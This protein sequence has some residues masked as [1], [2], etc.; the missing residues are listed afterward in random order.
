MQTSQ[1]INAFL[2]NVTSMEMEKGRVSNFIPPNVGDNIM[3]LE[4]FTEL[5]GQYWAICAPYAAMLNDTTARNADFQHELGHTPQPVA[6][7]RTVHKRWIEKYNYLFGNINRLVYGNIQ[8]QEWLLKYICRVQAL[9]RGF[10]HYDN[11]QQSYP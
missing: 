4:V 8:H 2:A 7:A 6:D 5:H 11:V 9:S 3:T 10:W 1:Q